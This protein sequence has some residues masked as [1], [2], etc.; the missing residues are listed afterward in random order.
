MYTQA[1]YSDKFLRFMWLGFPSVLSEVFVIYFTLLY[2][3]NPSVSCEV[4]NA[5]GCVVYP[6]FLFSGAYWQT[7]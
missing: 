3:A 4:Q 7:V 1:R 5:R 2:A 6:L